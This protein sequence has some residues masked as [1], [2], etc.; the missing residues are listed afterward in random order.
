MIKGLIILSA[1][2]MSA[3]SHASSIHCIGDWGDQKAHVSGEINIFGMYANLT[4]KIGDEVILK[5]G[6]TGTK[7]RSGQYNGNWS[8]K[9]GS[10]TGLA[11]P[12]NTAHYYFYAPSNFMTQTYFFANIYTQ[13][14]STVHSGPSEIVCKQEIN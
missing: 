2:L 4:F 12:V 13:T 9:L 8:F 1:V 6:S 5:N 10:E 7:L 11:A 14:G 3:L